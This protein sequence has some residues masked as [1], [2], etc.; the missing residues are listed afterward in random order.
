MSRKLFSHDPLTGITKYWHYD[1]D[2]D[3]AYIETVQDV[4]PLI[5][6]NTAL[7][8]EVTRLDRWG[9]GKKVADIPL[10][11]FWDLKTK[12]I[13]D[14]QAALRR[15]LNDPSNVAFRTFPGRV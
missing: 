2:T 7:R 13:L 1:P 10:H 9:D 3:R 8:N 12:G 4:Q 14:D 11:I 15:W 6:Q 5:D